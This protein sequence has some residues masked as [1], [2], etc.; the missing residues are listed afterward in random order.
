M[1]VVKYGLI[2]LVIV[3]VVAV[4]A[5]AV[6]LNSIVSGS[7]KEK[8]IALAEKQL[9]T[10]VEL[11]SYSLDLKSVLT[12]RPAIVLNKLSIAN[13][14]GFSKQNLLEAERVFAR[15]NLTSAL[16]KKI[17][18]S[19]LD[20]DSPQILIEAPPEGATNFETLLSNFQKSGPATPDAPPTT[21]PAVET[22]PENE[23]SITIGGITISN[24]VIE[25]AN[26]QNGNI[27]QPTV[28][29]LNM[30]LSD[31]APGRA[32]KVELSSKFFDS[33]NSSLNL[34]GSMGPFNDSGLPLNAQTKV[35]LALAEFPKDVLKRSLGD[36]AAAPGP[37]S[38]IEF[39]LA[40]D[41]DLYQS[42][43]G[44]GN[45]KFSKFMVGGH[46]A[47]QLNLSGQTPLDIQ[48]T[49]L[50]SAGEIN[51]RANNASLQLG[52][53]SWTGNFNATR[54]GSSLQG[55]LNGA[56]QKVDVNQM[57][58]SFASTPDKVFGALT[59]PQFQ[60]SFAG[61]NTDALKQSLN[62]NGTIRINNGRF[63][64]LSILAAIER[65][66]GGAD[67]KS[68]G[69]F[70][71]FQSNFN[72]ASQKIYMSGITVDGPGIGITGQGVVTFNEA[73]D[74]RLQSKLTGN[75]AELIKSKTA[76]F[77]KGDIIV[78]VTVTGNLDNPQV[79]PELKGLAR[80]AVQSTVK[81][82]LEGFF[83]KKK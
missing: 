44:K 58:T 65:A 22:K 31:L 55:S 18:I 40:L 35:I 82:V 50:I 61:K 11:D 2:A 14:S 79:R 76:G 19:T 52:N 15:I 64:G 23:M 77:M 37:D 41:G 4:S 28:K 43:L 33:K 25:L 69:E 48:A 67:S 3:L 78:P 80:S 68:T 72:I 66:L 51:V 56:V 21:A 12:L 42:T 30:T 71:Q 29:D 10:N 9:G 24:A 70:A 1:K 38:R 45:I 8:L 74:F 5:I 57:L 17:H 54:K 63:K 83:K 75:A 53:G 73:L 27:P 34:N 49:K 47:N 7:Q 20:I 16:S 60:I 81:G 6:I 26:E 39:D 36:L 46:Q 32:F 59:I 13:P 62:G